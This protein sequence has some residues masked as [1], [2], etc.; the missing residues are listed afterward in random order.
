M[1]YFFEGFQD[2][3]GRVVEPNLELTSFTLTSGP[4][5]IDCLTLGIC[6]GS[7]KAVFSKPNPNMVTSPSWS[8]YT[9]LPIYKT[10][11]KKKWVLFLSNTNCKTMALQFVLVISVDPTHKNSKIGQSIPTSLDRCVPSSAPVLP[12]KRPQKSSAG[13]DWDTIAPI[14]THYISGSSGKKIFLFVGDMMR[15]M[16]IHAS[17][18]L[19]CYFLHARAEKNSQHQT[20]LSLPSKMSACGV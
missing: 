10:K 14:Y 1:S 11:T 8:L 18:T 6:E 9:S 16:M 3:N 15:F 12:G 4:V 13:N 2:Y 19:K 5:C 20:H 17:A 7:H